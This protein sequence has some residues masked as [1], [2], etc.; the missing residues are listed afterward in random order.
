MHT[1]RVG[2]AAMAFALLTLLGTTVT[3]AAAPTTQH[4]ASGTVH[5]SGSVTTAIGTFTVDASKPAGAPADQASGTFVAEG[6]VV[7]V[8]L[9]GS[10]LGGYD[11]P[12]LGDAPQYHFRGPVTFLSVDGNRAGLIYPLAQAD[13][14]VLQGQA[15][16][17]T[18]QDNGPGEADTVGFYGPAPI[19]ELDTCPSALPSFLTAQSGD[20]TISR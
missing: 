13:P 3:A 17:I 8:S 11:L 6:D 19:G 16:L 5:V 4:G 1:I 20:I 9:T 12:L 15:I 10:A 2:L 14:P 7:P 18:I